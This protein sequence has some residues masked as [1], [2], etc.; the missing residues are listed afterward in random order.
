MRVL[1][2]PLA[3]NFYI[4]SQR[5]DPGLQKPFSRLKGIFNLATIHLSAHEPTDT[6]RVRL[7]RQQTHISA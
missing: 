6:G 2:F 3:A 5:R 1:A 7:G 4:P